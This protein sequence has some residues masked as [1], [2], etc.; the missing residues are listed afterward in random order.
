MLRS[1]EGSAGD[2]MSNANWRGVVG[3]IKP[4]YKSGSLVDFIHLLPDGVGVVP[5]FIGAREHTE[6]EYLRA[7]EI[8]HQ[9]VRELAQIG[10]DLIHPEGGPPFMLR[11][12]DSEKELVQ[13]WQDKHGIPVVTTGM[14]H[15]AALCA[16]GIRRFLGLTPYQG[17][18][19]DKFAAYFKAAGFDVAAMLGIP[20]DFARRYDLTR[21][22]IYRHIKN[23]FL[24]HRDVDGIY[25]LSPGGWRIVDVLDAEHDLG[26]P[27]IHPIAA[28]VWSVLKHLGVR[29]PMEGSGR[30]LELFP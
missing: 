9:R 5:L 24:S 2:F 17:A 28:G 1:M 30:L 21:E 27:I 18:I 22:E 3:V 4:T 8:Y 6:D 29:H 11:G 7:M 23:A 12:Y 20:I 15:C 10:V 19:N 13:G 26:L 25:L 14:S 16:M